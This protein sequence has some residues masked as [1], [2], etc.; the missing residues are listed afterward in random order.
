M[1][2]AMSADE[3]DVLAANAAFYDAFAERDLEAM[4]AI[5]S[6]RADIACVHPGWDGL[7]GRVAVMSSWRSILEGGGAPAIVC[8]RERVHLFGDVAF[9]VCV[10][11]IPNGELIATNVFVR[12]AGGWRMVHHHAGPI[13]AGVD[14]ESP[15][16]LLN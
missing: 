11:T 9:V 16:E 6:Q 13:A 4:D 5:W 12:E 10:E 3:R 8:A 15:P 1:L 7:S 2:R 14:D